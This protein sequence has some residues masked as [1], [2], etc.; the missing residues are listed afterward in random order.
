MQI[1]SEFIN[2]E[3]Q[4]AVESSIAQAETKTSAEMCVAIATDSGRYD[5]AEDIGGL[6]IGSLCMLLLW[7]LWPIPE[8]DPNSW[9]IIQHW[10]YHIG[11][12][13]ALFGGFILGAYLFSKGSLRLR[14]VP[15][16]EKKAEVEQSAREIFFDKSI[17]HTESGTGILIYIS[18]AERLVTILTDATIREN[19]SDKTIQY[20]CDTLTKT[21]GTDP[22]KGLTTVIESVGETL[23]PSSPTPPSAKT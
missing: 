22:V 10:H 20:H 2:K 12:L 8:S 9:A 19:L 6:A 21:L 16:S 4:N 7:N 13:A 5:R 23:S 11:W 3:Q 18:L 1:A 15:K 14:L 17:H